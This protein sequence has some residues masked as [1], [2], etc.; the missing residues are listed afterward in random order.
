MTL[1]LSIIIPTFNEEKYLPKLLKSL[2]KQTR[3]PAQ[4]IVADAF[5]LDQVRDPA[6]NS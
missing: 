3:K 5:S 2:Q 1:P 6:Y 4:V